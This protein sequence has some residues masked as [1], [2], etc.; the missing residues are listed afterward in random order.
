MER[1]NVGA[2]G[3]F[4]K[5]VVY[6]NVTTDYVLTSTRYVQVRVGWSEATNEY[7][8]ACHMLKLG[9]LTNT[10]NMLPKG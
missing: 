9:I 10:T 4:V 8:V 1:A 7:C 5:S 6:I 2:I 3:E